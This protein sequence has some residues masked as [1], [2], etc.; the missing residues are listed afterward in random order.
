[1]TAAEVSISSP[2][3]NRAFLGT[4]REE[5]QIEKKWYED[6]EVTHIGHVLYGYHMVWLD[7]AAPGGHDGPLLRVI[8]RAHGAVIVEQGEIVGAEVRWPMRTRE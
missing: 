5:Q 8:E 6:D 7:V 3:S 2:V 4:I 1:L